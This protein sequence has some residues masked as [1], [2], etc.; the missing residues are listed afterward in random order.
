MERWIRLSCHVYQRNK[1]NSAKE[2]NVFFLQFE[3][4]GEALNKK[5]S[6]LRRLQASE[7]GSER[8]WLCLASMRVDPAELSLDN[9]IFH[10]DA[11]ICDILFGRHA[12]YLH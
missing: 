1:L 9:N 7:T 5:S 3:F 10:S 12:S 4:F 6:P 8:I 2:C 11:E